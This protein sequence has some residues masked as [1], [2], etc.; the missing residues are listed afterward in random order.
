MESVQQRLGVA[1]RALDTLRELADLSSP[2][3]VERD[4]AI[5]RFEYSVETCWKCAAYCLRSHAGLAVASPKAAARESRSVGWLSDEQA[6]LA[7]AMSDDRNLTS[8]T[9]NE[10]LAERIFG[11]LRGY[12]DLMDG[13]LAAVELECGGLKS[14]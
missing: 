4:A 8:H 14:R 1:R 12:V 5:Q 11:A 10:A 9:Y 6:E 7:L 13:W 3:T 2:T